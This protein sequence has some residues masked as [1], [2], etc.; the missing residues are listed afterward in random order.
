MGQRLSLQPFA[1]KTRLK[2]A[3]RTQFPGELTLNDFF[4]VGQGFTM[5][6]DD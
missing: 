1:Q 4:L 3:I 6:D 2:P 5:A